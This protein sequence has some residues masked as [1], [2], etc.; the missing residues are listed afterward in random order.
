[1]KCLKRSIFVFILIVASSVSFAQNIEELHTNIA[2]AKH[3][4]DTLAMARCW[5]KLGVYYDNK[6]QAKK[7]NQSFLQALYWAS[8]IE[9][10]KAIASISNY[11]ASNYS[12]EGQADSAIY[13]YQVA[14]K[15]GVEYGD[16]TRIPV[17][18]M[19]LG[20]S[21]ADIGEYVKA[22]NYAISAIQIKEQINDLDN[23]AYYYQKVGEVYKNAGETE[24][25]E[26]YARR[27]YR[28][29]SNKETTSIQANAAIYNDLGGIA[30][31]HGNLD[32]ALLYY[33][34]LSTIGTA[35]NYPHAIGIALAN[36]AT[37]F[38]KKGD[39]NKALE[40]A[41]KAKAFKTGRGYQEIYDY[42]LLAELFLAKGNR[43]EA[44]KY[45]M[46]A[47][48]HNT[49][50][51]SPEEKMR[52]FRILYLI[53][54][55]GKNFEKALQWNERFKQ[56]SDSIRDKEIRTKI[57]DLEIAYQTQKKEQQIELLTTENE[58]KT[59]RIKAGIGIVS[60][61]MI[62]I[63]L[64][65]YILNIRKKQ[66]VLLQHNLQQQVLRAQMNPH[67]IFNAL[68]SIQNFMYK[69]ETKKAAVYLGNFASLTRSI[70]EH[71]TAEFVSLE[72][73]IET[74]QNYIELEKMRMQNSFSYTIDYNN[75]LDVAFIKIPPMLVQPFVENAIKHGMKNLN[76]P[77]ELVLQYRE[78]KNKIEIKVIDNGHGI[79]SPKDE[80]K[81][82][83]RSMSMQ[84]FKE[85]RAILDKKFRN[86]IDFSIVDRR[87]QNDTKKGTE[88]TII[89]PVYYD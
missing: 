57:L 88:V 74:L 39:L 29:M 86:K 70:L 4:N 6:Q 58:L 60:V 10:S 83:H 62:V 32:Q 16:S 68:G 1:M 11:L 5:Y 84:I 78:L 8:S 12:I 61:L 82:A 55:S 30:E 34:T 7:S 76:Y 2:Q 41:L 42:N 89:I 66:A 50:D 37:I 44:L 22:A 64:V 52:V 47:L 20:D 13:Y 69:N 59:Q 28:L 72:T 80:G 85:R 77:G 38:K 14:L 23:L 67:F 33:D 35:N 48:N 9:S 40:L 15:A 56:Q 25:W 75:K 26:E 71:S 31:Q 43:R 45:A 36:S 27:A 87:E 19:N 46:L 81:K 21:Y 49:I 17:I 73:E 3:N 53:E 63:L 65:I 18:L 79:N 51:N 54:K 24:K